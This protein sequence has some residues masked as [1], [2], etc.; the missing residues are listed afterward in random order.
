MDDKPGK[1]YVD[2]WSIRK[3]TLY[4]VGGAALLLIVLVGGGWWIVKNRDWLFPST[5]VPDGPKDAAQIVSFE[6]DVRVT[7]AATR[8]T[9]IVTRPTFVSAG[10]TIQTQADGRAQVKMI[11]GSMLSIRPDSTVVIRDSSSLFGGTDVR[12]SL[13]DGQINVKTEDQLE[14]AQNVVEVLESENRLQSQTDAS[15]KI[16]P[17]GG[18]EIRV[19]RGSVQTS[20]GG[21]QSLLQGDEFAAINNGR[22][23]AKEGLLNPPRLAAPSSSEQITASG[24]GSADVSFRWEAASGVAAAKHHLQVST[25]P[26]FVPDAIV[27]ERDS[28]AGQG[29]T[30]GNLAPGVYYWRVRAAAASGQTSDWSEPAR[31]TVVKN[32]GSQKPE[33]GEWKVDQVGG[34]I[35]II[36]GRTRP[37]AM[38]RSAGRETFSSADGSF[39]LQVS[40]PS[41]ETSVEI[42]DE[43][44]NRSVFVL[45]LKSSRVLRRY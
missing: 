19:S 41:G 21:E 13:D 31:F 6:G 16:N 22:L 39:R 26:F 7:R 12:V 36:N 45:S 14:N 38:V 24:R 34:G 5:T 3:S 27:V 9:I 40:A 20:I 35:F 18:G 33:A 8:E 28:L 2:W 11:D 25:S 32:G 1:F 23:T 42:S 29:F 43:K 10:D 37:G 17:E 15:F 44:G 30:Y 4:S